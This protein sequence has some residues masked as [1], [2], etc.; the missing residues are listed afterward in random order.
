MILWLVE[1]IFLQ[2][3][4]IFAIGSSFS[5]SWKYI[6]NESSVTTCDNGFSVTTRF[7]HSYFLKLLLPLEGDQ[8]FEKFD[9]C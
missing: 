6:L 3:L 8:Y 7:F 2:I 4:I 5:I 1:T 9:F